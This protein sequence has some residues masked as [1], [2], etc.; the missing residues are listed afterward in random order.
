M[1]MSIS[2]MMLCYKSEELFKQHRDVSITKFK[3]LLSQLSKYLG[4]RDYIA[5]IHILLY[6][7]IVCAG[8]SENTARLICKIVFGSYRFGYGI[9]QKNTKILYKL[10]N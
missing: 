3:E 7:M 8:W 2:L 4:E 6:I 1:D 5:G 10:I 9:C